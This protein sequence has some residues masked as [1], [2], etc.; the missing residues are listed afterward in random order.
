MDDKVQSQRDAPFVIA[1]AF[2]AVRKDML[3]GLEVAWD[4]AGPASLLV[5]ELII[6][7]LWVTAGYPLDEL[8]DGLKAY[9]SA[10]VL[11][12]T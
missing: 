9:L 8:L 4:K 10:P 3:P 11:K 5:A 1:Q 7:D 12:P 6:A 2:A